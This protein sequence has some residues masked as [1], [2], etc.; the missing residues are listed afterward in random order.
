MN[1]FPN[2]QLT[3]LGFNGVIAGTWWNV[4]RVVSVFF[5]VQTRLEAIF[6][7]TVS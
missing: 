6:R 7:V 1:G 4:P 5:T 2:Q 3:T